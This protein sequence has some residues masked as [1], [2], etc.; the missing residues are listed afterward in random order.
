MSKYRYQNPVVNDTIRL[1]LD[2]YNSNNFSDVNSF[3]KVEIYYLD[4]TARTEENPDGRTLFTTIDGGDVVREAE[5]QYYVDLVASAPEFVVGNYVDLWY[6]VFVE[7]EDTAKIENYFTI[8]PDLWFTSPLPIV[9]DFQFKFLPTRWRQGES[10]YLQI[11]ITP[12]VPRQS[13]LVRY[14]AN[15][16]IAA[17][18]TITIEQKC[19][20]CIP[21][22]SDLRIVL[23]DESVNYKEKGLAFYKW[24]TTDLDCGIYEVSAR[25]VFADNTYI[26]DKQQIQIYK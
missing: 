16:A 15:L 9:Y 6:M 4:D 7:D 21:C 2:V 24:D 14:Y 1:R 22:E 19:G 11:E 3:E 8:Y 5:G 18:I 13:D 25:L 17:D 26:S 12:L 20:E 23:E 10:K